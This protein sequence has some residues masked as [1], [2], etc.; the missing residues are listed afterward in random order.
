M[1]EC[2]VDETCFSIKREDGY[3]YSWGCQTEEAQADI[4]AYYE[5]WGQACYLNWNMSDTPGECEE[6][7]R[8]TGPVYGVEIYDNERYAWE[9]GKRAW[10]P[11]EVISCDTEAC[12]PCSSSALQLSLWLLSL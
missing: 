8:H 11:L 3:H 7:D 5:H 2:A 12:N 6:I 9:L 10:G 4:L 1:G